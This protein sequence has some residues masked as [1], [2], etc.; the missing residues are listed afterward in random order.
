MSAHPPKVAIATAVEAVGLDED[1][2]LLIEAFAVVGVR[3]VSAVWDAGDVHWSSFDAVLVRSTWDY[4]G[5][6]EE[7]LAWAAGF[8]GGRLFNDSRVLAWN[9]DKTYLRALADAGIPVVPTTW[10]DADAT[11]IVLPRAGNYVVKPSVSAGSKDT[12]RYREGDHAEAAEHVR[13]IQKS[14]R[15]T[16]VQPYV[17]SVDTYGETAMLYVDGRFSHAIRKGPLLTV[18]QGFVAGLYAEEEISNRRPSAEEYALADAV[19]ATAQ[20]LAG[21][22]LYAR[23]DVVQ[24]DDGRPQ[25]LELELTEPSLFLGYD[26]A[27]AGRL[28]AAVRSR[29]R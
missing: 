29:L 14:G 24:G 8:G 22:L 16:M 9:T 11:E 20:E 21:D 25:L 13:L 2:P 6:R 23:V 15:V 27:A 4:P 10:I 17:A 12:V 19:V 18:G 26:A 3:A 7:F 5:K 28:A 1:E